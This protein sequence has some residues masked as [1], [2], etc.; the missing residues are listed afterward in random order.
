MTEV[1]QELEMHPFYL[2]VDKNYIPI[3]QKINSQI[4]D[5]DEVFA[6]RNFPKGIDFTPQEY[7]WY[8][9]FGKLVTFSN[10]YRN[11]QFAQLYISELKSPRKHERYGI[12]KFDYLAYH[13]TI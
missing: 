3:V 12:H 8:S 4:M 2:E 11:L 6:K 7:Y 5:L 10:V 13:Y 1:L 9:V